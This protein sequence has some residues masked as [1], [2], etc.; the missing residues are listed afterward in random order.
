MS[1]KVI[2]LKR[3]TLPW[4]Q[5]VINRASINSRFERQKFPPVSIQL[6]KISESS[7][8]QGSIKVFEYL[9]WPL[10]L[11]E[12]Q[13]FVIMDTFDFNINC[14][15][16]IYI[17]HFMEI[18]ANNA[19]PLCLYHDP[20]SKTTLWNR[21][22]ALCWKSNPLVIAWP[23]IHQRWPKRRLRSFNVNG[24]WRAL[25]CLR[26]STFSRFG[27]LD[28]IRTNRQTADHVV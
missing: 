4:L 20:V 5:H 14:A 10:S 7:R 3:Q 2:T 22:L 21:K 12:W 17:F 6:I 16:C 15:S 19:P 23:R 18:T 11:L 9:C 1:V 24:C 25:N 28:L 13:V 27:E 26:D 8:Y